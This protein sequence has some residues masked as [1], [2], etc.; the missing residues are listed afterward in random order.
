VLNTRHELRRLEETI[1]ELRA[2][3]EE[4]W[5]RRGE[6][7]AEAE[8]LRREVETLRAAA[9]EAP[10]ALAAEREALRRQI[11][12]LLGVKALVTEQLA[13]ALQRLHTG[14]EVEVRAH[15]LPDGS[16]RVRGDAALLD[17]EH[18]G[19]LRIEV[20]PL[21]D[22]AGISALERSLAAAADVRDVQ[23]RRVDGTRV[24]LEVELERRTTLLR[25][26]DGH[27]PFDV[28]VVT[29]EPEQLVLSVVT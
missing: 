4:G 18:E 27:L 1:D 14:G 12:D 8:A 17:G 11:D 7:E 20:A 23:V 6:L 22:F 19:T 26:L 15:L 9:E 24:H 16:G 5:R 28:T 2:A 21:L 10:L 3:L 29:A 25:S 13:G